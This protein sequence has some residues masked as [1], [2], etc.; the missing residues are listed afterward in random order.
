MQ[1]SHS[2][3][4][5]LARFAVLV[6]LVVFCSKVY[7]YLRMTWINFELF[8]L[9]SQLGYTSDDL[10]RHEVQMRDFNF[11]FPWDTYC[12]A[13]LYY[14]TTLSPAEFGARMV[15]A[16]PET[17]GQEWSQPM[18]TSSLSIPDLRIGGVETRATILLPVSEQGKV[19]VYRWF[20]DDRRKGIS[21]SLFDTTGV[22]APFDYKNSNV[23]GSIVKLYK[24]GGSFPIWIDCPVNITENIPPLPN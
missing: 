16:L 11:I 24:S 14:T 10:M 7:L 12:D 5:S 4:A 21:I 8:A 1:R 6:L 18:L 19:I 20:S 17:E 23:T 3:L 22:R 9:A 15:Q 13:T 2:C